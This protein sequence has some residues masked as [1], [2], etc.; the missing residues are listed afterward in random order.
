[1]TPQ[2]FFSIEQEKIKQHEVSGA[3]EAISDVLRWL[4]SVRSDGNG[5][6]KIEVKDYS[7]REWGKYGLPA[8]EE[9]LKFLGWNV[10]IKTKRYFIKDDEF[11]PL[12]TWLILTP[13]SAGQL[14]G[15]A[16]PTADFS[17]SAFNKVRMK[18]LMKW[19][20]QNAEMSVGVILR[21]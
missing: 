12:K 8:V 16:F 1:M 11:F 19:I 13:K 9:H 4:K 7:L 3:K 18:C 21:M 2:E 15:I 6:I 10:Q 20:V 14:V 17:F 5:R